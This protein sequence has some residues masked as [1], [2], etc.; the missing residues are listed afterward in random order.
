MHKRLETGKEQKRITPELLPNINENFKFLSDAI[1]Y[2]RNLFKRKKQEG[3]K[4]SCLS[5][6]PNTHPSEVWRN[7]KN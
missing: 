6:S 4:Q 1:A 3:W 2:A 7:I 5:I